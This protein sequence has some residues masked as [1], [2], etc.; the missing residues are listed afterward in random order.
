MVGDYFNMKKYIILCQ[1]GEVWALLFYNTH[2]ETGF[3]TICLEKQSQQEG[4][5]VLGHA[6]FFFFLFVTDS[7]RFKFQTGS[8]KF[9]YG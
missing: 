6:S 8:K 7:D 9:C 3:I 2:S 5:E 4:N 1:H